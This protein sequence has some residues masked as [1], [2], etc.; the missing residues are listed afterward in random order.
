M[1]DIMKRPTNP[2]FLIILRKEGKSV[3]MLRKNDRNLGIDC[4]RAVSMLA[5]I[6]LHILG[7]GGLIS[8]TAANSGKY[9]L[10][11]FLNILCSC[12]VD[13]YGLTTGYLL[14]DRPFRLSR[15]G[16]LWLTTV[17]WSVA[18][19]CGF[20]LL[21][22]ESRTLSEAVSMFLPILR[23]RYWFFTAYFV[24]MLVS[25]VLNVVIH[26]LN[27][28]QFRCLLA[29]LFVVFGLIPVCSLGYDVMRISGGNHFAW[30]ISLYLIGGYIKVYC[31]QEGHTS[32]KK[33]R[34]L[35]CDLV[36]AL[37][38]LGYML[39]ANLL[40]LGNWS[41]L[42]LT[43]V[44]PLIFGEAVCLFLFFREWEIA[45]AGVGARLIRFVT[46]GIYAVYI[47]HVHPKVFWNDSLIALLRPWDDWSVWKVLPAVIG[48]ALG[49]FVV[50]ILMDRLRQW[51]FRVLKI[52]ALADR[53]CCRVENGL[54]KSLVG[55]C[56]E[57]G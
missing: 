12:A 11:N 42:L 37:V 49:V 39:L 44:S 10:L 40:G 19:S 50:C 21:V 45:P 35:L 32:R 5:V 2:N 52:D 4:L 43:N 18:V 25:P 13:A 53:I 22:P 30:M 36:L 7:Q 33:H 41:N 28:G 8:H 48:A 17:F 54:R 23:G 47:I 24:T 27:Q 26:S 15:L 1:T 56:K 3:A 9:Y 16:K 14:C 20:F 6:C 46:P 38:H 55:K 34:W 51:L 29:A 31:P 57:N